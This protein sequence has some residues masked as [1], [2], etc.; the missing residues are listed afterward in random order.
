MKELSMNDPVVYGYFRFLSVNTR[1]QLKQHWGVDGTACC[2]NDLSRLRAAGEYELASRVASEI[3]ATQEEQRREADR[4]RA[5]ASFGRDVGF[6]RA[7]E[8]PDTLA[9]AYR[10]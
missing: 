1:E 7:E 3:R 8:V 2:A 9:W 10:Q 4:H 6:R 5:F